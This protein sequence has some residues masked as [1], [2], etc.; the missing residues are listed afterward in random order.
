MA[1]FV[2]TTCVA[3]FALT[4]A[5]SGVALSWLRTNRH[6]EYRPAD[7]TLGTNPRLFLERF[8][9]GKP[10]TYCADPNLGW[11]VVPGSSSPNRHFNSQGIRGER[12]FSA[13]P[14]VNV[15]R[16]AAFGDSFTEG[17]EV[18]D[19]QTWAA[20]MST[21]DPRVEVMNYGVIG[22]GPDQAYLRYL[23]QG[24]RLSASIVFI[25]YM[26]ENLFR[27]L[28]T[29]RP[30]YMN[31]GWE[32]FSKPRF[33]VDGPG[34]RLVPNRLRAVEDYR[35]LLDSP[36]QILPELGRHDYFF[37]HRPARGRADF[38]A[39]VR[40]WKVS[41]TALREYSSGNT[42][43]RSGRYNPEHEAFKILTRL[44]YRFAAEVRTN[45]ARPIVLVLP[46]RQAVTQYRATGTRVYQPFLDHL[47][48][49]GSESVDLMSAF[50]SSEV[51][52][53]SDVIFGHTHYS[54]RGNEIVARYLLKSLGESG[55]LAPVPE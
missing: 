19:E 30:F 44:T 5:V 40:L 16:I 49:N 55:V 31:E 11:S 50:G 52:L 37:N 53:P 17:T 33:E 3:V 54:Q 25:G 47:A 7:W 10:S 27:L 12:V 41:F 39:T 4:E 36:G 14:A 28:N 1:L 34:I 22:Y 23:E 2:V 20:I 38:L 45:G 42:V 8:L 18:T 43:L 51:D 26:P 24:R 35:L 21:M 46:N 6:L 15:V 29:F 13:V 32:F 9:A 48:V